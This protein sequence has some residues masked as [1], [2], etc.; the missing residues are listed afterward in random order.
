MTES[1]NIT[2]VRVI[3]ADVDTLRRALREYRS[4]VA[5]GVR[6]DADGRVGVDAYLRQDQLEQLRGMPV[7]VE[8]VTDETALGQERQAEVG[9][10]NR[11]EDGSVPRGLGDLAGGE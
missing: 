1:E 2:R 8:V 7:E 11:Y 5:G 10:G 4:T 6:Q 9:E 3:A